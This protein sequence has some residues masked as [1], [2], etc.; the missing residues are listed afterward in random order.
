MLP[1]V[2]VSV[3]EY[4]VDFPSRSNEFQS[5]WSGRMT[6][7]ESSPGTTVLSQPTSLQTIPTLPHG[8]S[9][10]H[11]SRTTTALSTLISSR[12]DLS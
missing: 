8:D 3:S 9:Q 2:A 5:P 7:S 4:Y 6:L 1:K 10:L 12:R 11:G